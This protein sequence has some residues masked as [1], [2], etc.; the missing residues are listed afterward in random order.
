MKK[1]NNFQIESSASECC[2]IFRQ[3]Q[4]NVTYKSFAYKKNRVLLG[5]KVIENLAIFKTLLIFCGS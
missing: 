3:F 5:E 2:L 1:M 4:S